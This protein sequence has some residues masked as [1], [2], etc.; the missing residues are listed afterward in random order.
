MI[1]RSRLRA[2]TGQAAPSPVM[3][4]VKTV[5]YKDLVLE[6][7]SVRVAHDDYGGL[8]DA[9]ENLSIFY[10]PVRFTEDGYVEQIC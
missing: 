8:L 6:C 3:S 5:R 10:G 1:S 2:S 9:P 7:A 4:G